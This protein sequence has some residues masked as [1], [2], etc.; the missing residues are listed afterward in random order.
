MVKVGRVEG[1]VRKNPKSECL[2]CFVVFL[3]L[4]VYWNGMSTFSLNK[5]DTNYSL[6]RLEA[7]LRLILPEA[8]QSILH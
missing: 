2:F 8:N 7:I 4:G 6:S 1:E 5:K 3:A